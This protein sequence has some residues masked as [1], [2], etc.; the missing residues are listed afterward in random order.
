MR[1]CSDP[2]GVHATRL[3]D[4][5]AHVPLGYLLTQ[6]LGKP[7]NTELGE[8]V[9][10]VAALGDTAGYRADID[11][12]AS[13]RPVAVPMPLLAPVT[14]A[15]VPDISMPWGLLLFSRCRC[16]VVVAWGVS[17]RAEPGRS[18]TP[19]VGSW[20]ASSR[21]HRRPLGPARMGLV[22]SECDPGR[23]DGGPELPF[24]S[25]PIPAGSSLSLLTYTAEPGSSS[26][27]ALNLLARWAA[28][29]R[30]SGQWAR[31]TCGRE[32]G[33]AA[34]AGRRISVVDPLLAPTTPDENPKRTA[35][36]AAVV[37]LQT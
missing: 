30:A 12:S 17:P 21:A 33:Q 8:D 2:V 9:H 16:A 29:P 6:R 13:R 28:R 15:T 20:P 10:A 34:G 37:I 5:Y 1:R 19:G 27:D 22:F 26:H 7:V 24:E 35:A 4:A 36:P 31:G 23:R 3:D 32:T 25:F 18:F 14:S 11:H